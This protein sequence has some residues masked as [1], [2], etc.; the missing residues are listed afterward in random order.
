MLK[1]ENLNVHVLDKQILTDFNLK[2]QDGEIHV[3]MGPNG[4]GKS[5]ICKTILGDPNYQITKGNIYYHDTLLNNLDTTSRARLGI[6]LLNQNPIGIEGVTN[7]E[8]LRSALS[9]KANQQIDIF[10]FNNK[11]LK[12]C[13]EL[14]LPSSFIH[15]D[16]NVGMSGGERK[17]NELLHLWMLEPSFIMLDEIDSGLDVDALKI[18]AKSINK[19]YQEYH[20]SILIIT[21]HDQILKYL[22]PDYVH[23]MENGTIVKT[24]NAILA[25]DIEKNGF[26]GANQ[27]SE[28]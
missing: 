21:H 1:I 15:R 19:Y 23:I 4:T 6:F 10:A 5:T 7:A 25:E 2:I 22:K 27:V 9:E 8:M 24:G 13:Q 3:L 17:K 14:D 20:P 12:L 18:V 26:N 16:I 28:K 11:L